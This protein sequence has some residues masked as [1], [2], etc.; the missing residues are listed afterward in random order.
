M[1]ANVDLWQDF[2]S[3]TD[4]SDRF[5]DSDFFFLLFFLLNELDLY[6]NDY[7]SL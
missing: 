7:D 5:K 2:E 6:I 3:V 1:E 4:G